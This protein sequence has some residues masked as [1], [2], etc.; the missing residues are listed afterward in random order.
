MC[1]MIS[2]EQRWLTRI[3]LYYYHHW[4]H[5]YSTG[6]MPCYHRVLFFSFTNSII[7]TRAARGSSHSTI[8]AIVALL[9]HRYLTNCSPSDYFH[10]YHH[11]RARS[12]SSS[13]HILHALLASW[14]STLPPSALVECLTITAATNVILFSQ[15]SYSHG[16]LPLPMSSFSRHDTSYLC[17]ILWY[18]YQSS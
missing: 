8:R 16:H 5:H 11:Y 10:H 14:V 17:R 6:I 4:Y 18:W 7:T 2:Y 13:Y 9:Y 3:I 15:L 1:P 12:I